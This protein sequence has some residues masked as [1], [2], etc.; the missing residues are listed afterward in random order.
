MADPLAADAAYLTE[1]L[2]RSGI[3]GAAHVNDVVVETDRQL[4]LSRIMRLRLGYRGSLDGAP[5]TIILKTRLPPPAAAFPNGGER[6]V[7]FYTQVAAALPSG[8]VPRCYDAVWSAETTSWH[9]LLE[10]LTDTHVL[11]TKWPLPPSRAQSQTIIAA[12]A[13]LHAAWWDDKRLGVSVGTL[14]DAETLNQRYG[15]LAELFAK[16][17]DRLG[18]ELPPERRRLY[19]AVFAAAPRL[20]LRTLGGRDMT[21]VHGDAHVWNFFIPRDEADGVRIFDWDSWRINVPT[22]DLAYMMAVHWYPNRRRRMEQSMLDHYHAVLR[23]HGVAGYD[24]HALN[25]DYR[26]SVLLQIMTPV[27]QAANNIPPFIWWSH[28]Q[29]ILLAVDDLGCHELL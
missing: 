14:L 24:R 28:L 13:R 16:F 25:E 18:E 7:A 5:A 23:D 8:V 22:N 1:V 15:S 9:L 20:L 21:I 17:A 29:R 11:A 10:D 19:E 2:R 4:I 26:W 27:W 12:L 6:E 3:L